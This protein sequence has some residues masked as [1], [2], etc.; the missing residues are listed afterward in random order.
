MRYYSVYQGP[1]ARGDQDLIF[2]KD[3]FCWPA[4]VLPFIWPAWRGL[5]LVVLMALVL[6]IAILVAV[7]G[8]WLAPLTGSVIEALV[9]L[10]V[11]FEGNNLRRW[12]KSRRGWREVRMVSGRRLADAERSFF[13]AYEVTSTGVLLAREGTQA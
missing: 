5:W 2:I 10:I 1:E 3:G 8:G 13:H 12:T 6:L 7:Q 11:A 9:A 4:L